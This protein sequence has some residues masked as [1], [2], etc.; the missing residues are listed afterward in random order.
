MIKLLIQRYLGVLLLCM[1]AHAATAQEVDVN[2]FEKGIQQPAIQVFD[3]RTA[4]EYNTGHLPNALQADYT[5]KTEFAERVKYLDKQKPV[6]VYCLSGGRSHAAA[7]WMRE[8]GFRKVVEME[9]GVRSWTAAGKPLTGASTGVKQLAVNE[10]KNAVKSGWVL[11]DVGAE[12]CPPCRAMSPVLEQFLQKHP[13][14]KLVKVD[15]GR[16]QDVMK[17]VNA[18]SLPTFIAY[19]D[20]KETGRK[21]G[22]VTLQELEETLR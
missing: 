17:A 7:Q 22:V 5:N 20:G 14:V 18:N 21:Q 2:T 9:G 11:V 1:L 8:N 15:G 13:Q 19:K 10:F 4:Q 3:V 12:W 6:Y 16:D